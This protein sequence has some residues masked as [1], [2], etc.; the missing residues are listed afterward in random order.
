MS[1]L[2]HSCPDFVIRTFDEVDAV[3]LA[4][5]ESLT[6][7]FLE[8]VETCP[9]FESHGKSQYPPFFVTVFDSIADPKVV[10][11]IDSWHI[12]VMANTVRDSRLLG[13]AKDYLN[14]LVRYVSR[15][16]FL[17]NDHVLLDQQSIERILTLVTES[18]S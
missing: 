8:A 9:W 10:L 16:W 11:D 2:F 3:L 12:L 1:Y 18:Q 5:I 6:A 4:T 7:E 17:P 14:A 15:Y 13:L